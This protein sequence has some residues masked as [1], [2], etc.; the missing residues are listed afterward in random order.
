MPR[1]GFAR[2]C[3]LR[4]RVCSSPFSPYRYGDVGYFSANSPL[5]GAKFVREN[6]T[7]SGIR[8]NLRWFSLMGGFVVR[9]RGSSTGQRL[10]V[11]PPLSRSHLPDK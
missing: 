7:T 2:D 6:P 8:P 11:T 4:Q 1:E 3:L 9:F 10:W 5:F